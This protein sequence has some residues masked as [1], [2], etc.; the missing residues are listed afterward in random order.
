MERPSI[1]G[2][3]MRPSFLGGAGAGVSGAGDGVVA[4]VVLAFWRVWMIRGDPS[5]RVLTGYKSFPL[6]R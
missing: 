4:W 2:T 1:L 3:F 6:P 5:N